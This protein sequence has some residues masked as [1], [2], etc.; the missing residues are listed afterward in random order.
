MRYDFQCV[1]GCFRVKREAA[2]MRASVCK[3]EAMVFNWKKEGSS[4]CSIYGRGTARDPPE[5]AGEICLGFSHR[6][7]TSVT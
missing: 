2:G 5:G 1:M 6:P 4:L 3:Y 7:V